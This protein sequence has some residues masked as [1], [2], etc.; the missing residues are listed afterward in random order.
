MIT[1]TC[2]TLRYNSTLQRLSSLFN[3]NNVIYIYDNHVSVHRQ[4]NCTWWTT[5]CKNFGL[6][7]YL[8][9]IRSTC[10][11]RCLRP[12]SG[13]IDCIYSFWYCPPVLLP[14][15]VLNEMKLQ[16]HLI[17]DT[18]RQ[19]YRWTISEAVNSVKCSWRW[20]KTSPETWK[21]IRNKE[22]S[23]NNCILLV[24][25]YNCLSIV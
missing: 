20:E 8:F 18:S 9:L 1:E 16:F 19:Q 5:R 12:S 10:F 17:L 6:F 7:I 21:P 22:I 14:A 13:A 15:G 3:C 23:Q 25:I 4:Y 24:V 11:G 2:P